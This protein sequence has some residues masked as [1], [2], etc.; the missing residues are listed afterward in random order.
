MVVVEVEVVV[1]VVVVV[2]VV[3]VVVGVAVAVAVSHVVV[4]TLN[5]RPRGEAAMVSGR[6]QCSA[7]RWRQALANP[8]A[9]GASQGLT[10]RGQRV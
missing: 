4:V 10:G 1:V 3:V 9:A 5:L 7:R 6:W 2:E 8:L